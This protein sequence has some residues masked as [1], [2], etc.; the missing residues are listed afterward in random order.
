MES[1]EKW[2]S[3]DAI[4]EHLQAV[5]DGQIKRFHQKSNAA[6]LLMV[7]MTSA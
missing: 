5:H 6:T 7:S 4:C 3:L 2:V 1:T